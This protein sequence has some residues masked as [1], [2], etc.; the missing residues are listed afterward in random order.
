M[1]I[2]AVMFFV[3]LLA[4][5]TVLAAPLPGTNACVVFLGDGITQ[6]RIYTRY[7]MNFFALHEP[8]VTRS[9][10]NAGLVGDGE[11]DRAP[12]GL[13]RLQ[14]DV[15]DFA[16]TL[17]VVAFG[18]EDA[19]YRAFD[20]A[21]DDDYLRGLSAITTELKA[22]RIQ[23]VVMTPGCV[24]P[25]F[26]RNG[27]DSAGYNAVLK[28]YADGALALA[29]RENIP[30]AD[31]HALLESFAE[32]CR[33]AHT[34][35]VLVPEPTRP[36]SAVHAVMAFGLLKALGCEGPASD[37][38][39]DAVGARVLETRRCT[40]SALSA[41]SNAVRFVRADKGYPVYLDPEARGVLPLLPEAA[42]MN[43]YGLTVTG[44][45][46]GN[47]ALTVDGQNVGVFTAAQGKS[48]VALA[49]CAGP[50]QALGEKVT[51][52]SVASEEL[53]NHIWWD[54]KTM[55]WLPPEAD[56]ERQR[57]LASTLRVL[58]ER[59]AERARVAADI[60][61]WTWVLTREP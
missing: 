34:N 1:R 13:K 11:C 45:S 60:Q 6:Q 36:S 3:L 46:E 24:G 28:R 7:V 19:G 4:A 16:P 39:L 40:I 41:I 38:V 14:R 56:P 10:R 33:A 42:A 51:A 57:L 49:G 50:W 26:L 54:V 2:R 53:Y 59:D 29:G 48:G 35:L 17:A 61:P 18:M 32:R 15:L 27:L 52:R 8:G 25:A 21:R 58:A 44:L 47:W 22:H 20:Q 9:F 43:R 5:T 12:G 30:V 23:P 37:A 31:I 55:W